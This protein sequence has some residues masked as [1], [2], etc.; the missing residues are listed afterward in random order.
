MVMCWYNWFLKKPRCS[1]FVYDMKP[2][3]V[4][5]DTS[6]L[7]AI[8]SYYSFET[9]KVEEVIERRFTNPNPQTHTSH[10]DQK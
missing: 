6:Y 4:V 2:D 10:P 1:V 7:Y 8:R 5:K 9:D 3:T